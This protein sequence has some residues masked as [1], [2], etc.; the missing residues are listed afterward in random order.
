MADGDSFR[1]RVFQIISAIPSGQVTTYGNVAHLA[2][3]PRAS[4]QVGGV[5]KKLPKGSMLPW[6]R[7]INRNGEISLRGEDFKRQYQA[8]LEEGVSFEKGRVD[9][10]RYG[11]KW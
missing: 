11:W 9:L 10:E 8:L 5:L 7:V 1:Q 6:Y 2:G 3:S 4:R